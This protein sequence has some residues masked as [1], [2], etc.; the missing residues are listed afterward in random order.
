[1]L[2]YGKPVLMKYLL[3]LLVLF[4]SC[5]DHNP[6]TNVIVN[7]CYKLK[8]ITR[9]KHAVQPGEWRSA[10]KEA[11]EPFAAY[12][13][14]KPTAA[15]AQRRKL[16]VVQL[17][18]FD[19]AAIAILEQTK[20]YLQ[21]FFQMPVAGLDPVDSA[22]IAR[23]YW[24][25]NTHGPQ[26]KTAVLLD[27]LLPAL[28]PD[29]AFALIAFSR[30]DLYPDEDW[31]FVFGQASLERRVG[32]WSL[33]R[34]GDYKAN[35]ALYRQC[36]KRM[37]QVSAH[38]TGHMFGITHCVQNECCMNGS[39]SLVESDGQPLWLCWECQAKICWN[40]QVAPLKP[41]S[42]LLDFYQKTNLDTAATSYYTQA[43]HL[44]KR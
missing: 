29:S 30:Y 2:S 15:T 34:L 16:Y 32:V 18:A 42:A 20:A 21:A 44:L 6:G 1:M 22:I 11:P 9:A 8:A 25:S 23:Q 35:A 43:L 19:P 40:R 10:Y 36:L 13:A 41:I 33:A 12:C 39:N 31:N 27:S 3:L 14:R 7:E 4:A 37:L 28:L 17:G 24:R 38:E 5:A 26:I